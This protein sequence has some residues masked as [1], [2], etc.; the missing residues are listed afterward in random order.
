LPESLFSNQKSQLGKILE[1]LWWEN[2]DIF[3]NRLEYF[4]AIL[5]NSWPFGIVCGILLYFYQF[6][7]FGP[8]EIWQ[9]WC[10]SF[11]IDIWSQSYDRELQRQR[12][13]YLQ[14]TSR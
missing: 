8:R 10:L 5:Y 14:R 6:D 7:M 12:G 11:Y 2:V 4:M 3:Y 9:P 1:C 13:K